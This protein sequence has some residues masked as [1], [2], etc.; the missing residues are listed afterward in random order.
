[1]KVMPRLRVSSRW[2]GGAGGHVEEVGAVG[3]LAWGTG[4]VMEGPRFR[5]SK[6]LPKFF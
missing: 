5:K 4:V 2:H 6:A 3:V 1:M